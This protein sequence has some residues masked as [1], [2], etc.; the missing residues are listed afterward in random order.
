MSASSFSQSCGENEIKNKHDQ[1]PYK[2]E[3][4]RGGGFVGNICGE[5][6]DLLADI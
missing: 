1:W 2:D 5:V 3:E 4:K 6:V